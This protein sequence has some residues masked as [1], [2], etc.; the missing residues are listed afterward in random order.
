MKNTF[1]ALIVAICL[2]AAV[3]LVPATAS[4]SNSILANEYH[5]MLSD[6]LTNCPN[7]V[8]GTSD[9]LDVADYLWGK[10]NEV[11]INTVRFQN[12]G[13]SQYDKNVIASIYAE[14]EKTIVI[15]AHYDT[16]EAEGAN[17]NA[18]GVVTLLQIAKRL[19]EQ[20]HKLN[21][22][23]KLVAFAGEE[24]GLLGSAY[25]V[26]Q[27]TQNQRDNLALMINIDAV[28]AG[29]NLYVYCENKSTPL[30][31]ELLTQGQNQPVKLHS[32]P[33]SAGVYAFVDKWGYGYWEM[34][35][36]SDHTPFRLA[37]IPTALFFSGN[38]K[39][40]FY[41]YVESSNVQNWTMNSA[42]DTLQSLQQ[43]APNFADKMAT[44]AQMVC[45]LLTD[46]SSVVAIEGAREHL[47]AGIVY[48]NDYAS[49]AAFVVALIAIVGAVIYY[50]KL[51]K[52]AFV[53][54]AEVKTPEVFTSPDV[55]DV[56]KF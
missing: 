50:K 27:L 16:V 14:K 39:G 51:K 56:F 2:A 21:F 24:L 30:L 5:Q 29:D 11:G 23:V 7:R 18:C 53:G 37:G 46:E 28:A 9:M 20:K 35:Q 19:V 44:V 43:N 15:G 6:F 54:V 41:G 42:G 52:Q 25:Y 3:V 31:N 22:N 45:N 4:A 38:Y 36:N 55:N 26:S 40:M 32:K 34:A 1:W 33:F 49:I 47:T 12:V 10:F 8:S 13:D 17:D 48:N